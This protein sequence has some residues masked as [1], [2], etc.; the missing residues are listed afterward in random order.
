M[1]DTSRLHDLRNEIDK[2]DE[3]IISLVARRFVAT[4]AVGKFKAENGLGPVDALREQAQMARYSKLAAQYGL[5]ADVI[6]RVFRSI[7]EEVIKKH[8]AIAPPTDRS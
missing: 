7:I 4:D 3:A 6:G 2:I 5:N 8:K 1:H